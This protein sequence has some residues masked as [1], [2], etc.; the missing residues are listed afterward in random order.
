[1][2]CEEFSTLALS[3]PDTQDAP[4]FEKT[5]FKIKGKKIFATLDSVNSLAI[6][7]LSPEDQSAFCTYN[8]E[9][10]YPIKNKWGLQGWTSFDI[11]KAPKKLMKEALNAA[12]AEV[13]KRK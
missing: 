12:F 2:N 6:L 3:F 8:A 9:V 5:A 1:M 7:K 10:V 11:T 13:S 4:H